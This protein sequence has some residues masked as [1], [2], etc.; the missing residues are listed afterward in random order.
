MASKD[1]PYRVYRGGRVKGPVGQTIPRERDRGR[2]DGDGYRGS[3][4][5]PK[6]KRRWGRRVA[7]L[8]GLLVV[9]AVVWLVLGYLAF[10]NGVQEANQRLDR[11]AERALAVQDGSLLTSPGNL[12]VLGVDVGPQKGRGGPGRSDSIMLIR[13]DPDEHRLAYLSIP[14]DLRVD[15]PGHGPDKINA[16]YAIGGPA[17]AIDTVE[18][19]TGLDVHH[20][21]VVDFASF[22]AVVDAIGGITVNI[23]KPILSNNFD[24][25]RKTREQC[26]RWKGW[27]FGRGERKLNGWRALVYARIRYN[28]L[29]PNESDITRAARQQQ[30]VQALADEVTS[31]RTFARMPFIGDDLVK[32]LATDLSAGELLQIGWVKFRAAE[33]KT[34][35]CRLGGEPAD[36]GGASVLQSSE[37][38]ALAVAMFTGESA[39]QRPPKGQPFAPGCFVGRAP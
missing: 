34:V 11:R 17:L 15:V 27:R 7:L 33:D 29:D 39:P 36:V 9:L 18:R 25:P 19:L 37:D 31:F 12:L 2:S 38:N 13:T 1:K 22:P 10:R 20:V 6:K 35:R 28:R 30:V 24:C 21:A 23:R 5:A 32:P 26:L 16:A 3:Y 8:V 14:R 4:A